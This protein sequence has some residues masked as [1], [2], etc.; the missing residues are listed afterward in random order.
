MGYGIVGFILG[1]NKSE[2]L[3]LIVFRMIAM[4][5]FVTIF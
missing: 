1:R 3:I 2:D 4:R 5:L